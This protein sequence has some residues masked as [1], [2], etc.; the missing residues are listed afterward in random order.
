MNGCT[1]LN[2]NREDKYRYNFKLSSTAILHNVHKK[3]PQILMAT[4]AAIF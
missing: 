4:L 2:K 1:H 3:Y